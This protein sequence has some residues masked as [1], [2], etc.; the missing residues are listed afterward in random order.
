MQQVQ[1]PGAIDYL[2]PLLEIASE[3]AQRAWLRALGK[4]VPDDPEMV[5]YWLIDAHEGAPETV[6]QTI[7]E[8]SGV[9][10]RCEPVGA[11]G[12]YM[13]GI[14]LRHL[15][16]KYRTFMETEGR[17]MQWRVALR[18]KYVDLP[19][20]WDDYRLG[21]ANR[22]KRGMVGGKSA[23]VPYLEHFRQ[24]TMYQIDELMTTRRAEPDVYD[25]LNSFVSDCTTEPLDEW[26]LNY[27]TSPTD[28]DALQTYL[29]CRAITQEMKRLFYAKPFPPNKG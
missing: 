21:P 29:K 23:W 11:V 28:L 20:M 12:D 19:F 4:E 7:V 25:V 26:C 24:S 5:K 18:T 22:I 6:S 27:G 15:T 9:Q 16:G 13:L 2:D 8:T 1:M 10:L 3:T 17:M 14:S